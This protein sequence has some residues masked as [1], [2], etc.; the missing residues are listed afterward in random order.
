M[1]PLYCKIEDGYKVLYTTRCKR[2]SLLSTINIAYR[3][4]TA[5][6]SLEEATTGYSSGSWPSSAGAGGNHATT[7]AHRTSGEMATLEF[8]PWGH[9]ALTAPIM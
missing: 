2:R 8:A 9:T 3:I 4:V 6:L 5:D 1:S 7:T